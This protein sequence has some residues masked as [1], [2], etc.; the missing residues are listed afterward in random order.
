MTEAVL[1]ALGDYSSLLHTV[2]NF[3]AEALVL[4]QAAHLKSVTRR[5]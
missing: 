2:G 1:H 4:R 5:C 3:D